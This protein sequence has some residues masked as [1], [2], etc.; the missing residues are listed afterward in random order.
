MNH[1][2][3]GEP[4][5]QLRISKTRINLSIEP[6]DDPNGCF[7]WCADAEPVACLIPR[8]EIAYSRNIRQCFRTSL[9]RHGQRAQFSR[10]DVL[11]GDSHPTK[12]D[13]HLPTNK[14]GEGESHAA[15]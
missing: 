13:L 10:L 5:F 4:C 9:G 7:P 6:L 8:N 2:G 14:V 15:I 1:G 12:S 11:I 3:F